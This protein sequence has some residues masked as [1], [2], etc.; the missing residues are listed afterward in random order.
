LTSSSSSRLARSM[1]SPS[2]VGSLTISP[3]GSLLRVHHAERTRIVERYH[4]PRF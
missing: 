1:S 4:G 2:P 3:E